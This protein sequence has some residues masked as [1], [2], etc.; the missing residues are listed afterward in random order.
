MLETIWFVLWGLLWAV[1]FILDGF[2]FGMG[3][4][5]PFLAKNETEKRIVYNAAGPFWDGNEVWL[6]TAGGATFAAFPVAYAVLFSSFY[7]PLYLLLF[8]LIFRAASFEFRNKIDSD[9]WRKFWDVF[10]FLGGFLPALLLGVAFANLFRGIP[11]DEAGV[12]HGNLLMLLN[13]YALAGGILFVLMFCVHGALWLAIKSPGELSE[14]AMKT[15]GCL[16]GYLLA[17]ALLFLGWSYKETHLFANYAKMPALLI[18]PILAVVSL[19]TLYFLIKARMAWL[20]WFFSALFILGVTFFGVLGMYPAL[21]PSNIS[22]AASITIHNGA[23]T[24]LTLSIMLYSVLAILPVVIIYQIWVYT[25]FSHKIT[26][27]DLKSEHSY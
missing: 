17:V 20:S 10:Q 9:A 1:Y 15:A 27:E 25:V 8:A 22:E 23:S 7:A 12:Y 13:P 16:W 5:F 14:R 21:I 4:L 2:D 24:P 11:L 26:D 19:L 18:F 3:M 6:I